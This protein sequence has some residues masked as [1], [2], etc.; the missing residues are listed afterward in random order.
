MILAIEPEPRIISGQQDAPV[1][2]D[3]IAEDTLVSSQQ[4]QTP[5]EEG[6]VGSKAE[7]PNDID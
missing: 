4:P 2:M 6:S 5:D 3:E 7:E 1:A